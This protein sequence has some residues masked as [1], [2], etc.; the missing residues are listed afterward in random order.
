MSRG[1]F[2]DSDKLRN[3]GMLFGIAQYEVTLIRAQRS[4]FVLPDNA[5]VDELHVSINLSLIHI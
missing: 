2:T 4:G 3:L 1:V 5:R